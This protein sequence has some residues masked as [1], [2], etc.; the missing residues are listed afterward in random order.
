LSWITQWTNYVIILDSRI[1]IAAQCPIVYIYGT[2]IK[3]K[4]EQIKQNW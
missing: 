1:G 3:S 2:G 4:K